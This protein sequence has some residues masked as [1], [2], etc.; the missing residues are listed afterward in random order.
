MVAF[1]EQK[2]GTLLCS[3]TTSRSWRVELAQCER[4]QPSRCRRSGS[5]TGAYFSARLGKGGVKEEVM[6][7]WLSAAEDDHQLVTSE[8]LSI[9][10]PL[11]P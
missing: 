10:S 4:P 6:R 7:Q 11:K 8:F 9:A 1:E 3:A 2:L 5:C